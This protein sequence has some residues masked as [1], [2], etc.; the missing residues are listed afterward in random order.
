MQIRA[1]MN[2]CYGADEAM[3]HMKDLIRNIF[4]EQAH[5]AQLLSEPD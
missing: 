2:H 5:I 3:E 1:R 4:P